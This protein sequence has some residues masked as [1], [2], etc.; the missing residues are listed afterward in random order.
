MQK[1]IYIFI[2]EM[3]KGKETTPKQASLF[4]LKI[5]LD[6]FVVKTCEQSSVENE[7]YY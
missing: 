7:E 5:K 2:I 3:R 6:F 4:T 1:Q